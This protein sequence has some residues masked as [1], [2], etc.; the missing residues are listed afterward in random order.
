MD[1]DPEKLEEQFLQQLDVRPLPCPELLAILDAM[2]ATGDTERAETLAELLQES[3][4]TQAEPMPAPELAL[5]QRR[6]GYRKDAGFRQQARE[7]CRRFQPGGYDLT[8]YAGFDDPIPL[9]DC[10]QRLERLLDLVPGRFCYNKSWGFG[11]IRDRNDFTGRLSVDFGRKPGHG[12]GFA[13]AAESCMLTADDHPLAIRHR[14]KAAYERL[15]REQP[16]ELLKSVLRHYGPMNAVILQETM[17]RDLLVPEDEWKTFWNESRRALRNDASVIIPSRKNE[18]LTFLEQPEQRFNAAWLTALADA[19]EPDRILEAIATRET[20]SETPLDTEETRVFSDRLAHVLSA[21]LAP[22]R[23]VGALLMIDRLGLPLAEDIVAAGWQRC[24]E[25][26]TLNALLA[27]LTLRTLRQFLEVSKTKADQETI[28]AVLDLAP[29][30]PQRVTS[31]LVDFFTTHQMETMLA[32]RLRPCFQGRGQPSPAWIHYFLRNPD[33][34]ERLELVSRAV[35]PSLAISLLEFRGSKRRKHGDK[36][37][38]HLCRTTAIRQFGKAMTAEQRRDLIRRLQRLAQGPAVD[39]ARGVMAAWIKAYPDL[40]ATATS[41]ANASDSEPEPA[42]RLTSWRSW[43]EKQR[44]LDHLIKKEIP[45]NAREIGVA[46]SYGDLRQNH[47]YKAAKEHQTILY[48]RQAE[49]ERDL[50]VV[51]GTDFAGLPHDRAGMATAVD[52]RLDNGK[53]ETIIIL[54]EWDNEPAL[55]I[56][57]CCSERA[58]R[59][60]GA[61]PGARIQLPGDESNDESATVISIR[62]LP[63]NA[64]QWLQHT[65]VNDTQTAKQEA[66]SS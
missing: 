53:E 24:R 23:L 61:A 55:N 2:A 54:G 29:D 11:L 17:I 15:R 37:A 27:G 39:L 33:A 16:G 28:R 58:K 56:I 48:R 47:E 46:R 18:P 34:G 45:A 30:A 41:I 4:T 64:R 31:S 12:L 62:E 13:Y 6:A 8:G 19:N 14:D 42:V 36:P 1:T 51:K 49:L 35:L 52:L 44:Q 63:E 65:P 66:T 57:S 20:E 40:A 7:L 25:P 60:I 9:A 10:L 38:E 26:E 59:L 21:D 43:N 22:D 32:D 5:L 3:L 50:T